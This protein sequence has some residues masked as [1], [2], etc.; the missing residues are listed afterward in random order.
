MCVYYVFFFA[1]R[2]RHTSCALVTGFQTCALPISDDRPDALH[3]RYRLT[4]LDT[5]KSTGAPI[6]CTRLNESEREIDRVSLALPQECTAT[7]D[8]QLDQICQGR[9]RKSV[10]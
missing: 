3:R 2:R 8:D 9:D 4:L 7:Y 6:P 1:S 10:V 5:S